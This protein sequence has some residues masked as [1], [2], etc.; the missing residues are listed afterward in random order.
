MEDGE[1]TPTSVYTLHLG[2]QKIERFEELFDS[3]LDELLV[4][5]ATVHEHGIH[6]ADAHLRNLKSKR[7]VLAMGAAHFERSDQLS[8]IL[9]AGMSAGETRA[10]VLVKW[11]LAV[12]DRVVDVDL[13]CDILMILILDDE[14]LAVASELE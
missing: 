12:L 2:V 3:P 6:V 7:D 4:E 5:S 9:G 11:Q 10:Q 1:D 8:D 13:E 14:L